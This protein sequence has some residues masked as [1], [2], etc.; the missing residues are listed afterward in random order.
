M[1]SGRSRLQNRGSSHIPSLRQSMACTKPGSGSIALTSASFEPESCSA[2][3]HV[4]RCPLSIPPLPAPLRRLVQLG[5]P[6]MLEQVVTYSSVVISLGMAGHLGAAALAAVL[7]ARAVND[8]AGRQASCKHSTPHWTNQSH[9]KVRPP[10]SPTYPPIHIHIHN[11]NHSSYPN[12]ALHSPARSIAPLSPPKK[13]R[14]IVHA[15]AHTTLRT[16]A[17]LAIMAGLTAAIDTFATQAY[18]AGERRLIG[19]TLQRALA[20]VLLACIPLLGLYLQA[21][22]VL[23]VLGQQA[24]LAALTAHYLRLFSPMLV[25]QGV[26]LCMY[27]YLTAQ[28]EGGRCVLVD[29]WVGGPCRGGGGHPMPTA[30]VCGHGLSTAWNHLGALHICACHGCL[31]PPCCLHCGPTS[32]L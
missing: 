8:I 21:E 26:G 1:P 27:R 18:G 3:R 32:L 25:L 17:G 4:P 31:A 19:V 20:L 23:R 6:L 7:L 14:Y 28:G 11:Q 10:P 13:N 12:L 9:R 16:P 15:H 30:S 24:E 2:H 22:P 5:W 29:G